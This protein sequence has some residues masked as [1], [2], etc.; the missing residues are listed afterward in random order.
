MIN[1][2]FEPK[3]C[4]SEV[5]T[6]T[7]IYKDMQRVVRDLAKSWGKTDCFNHGASIPHPS[8]EAVV[9]IIAR[10]RRILFPGYFTSN[11]I[12][13]GN[14]EY[15]LGQETTELF[16]RLSE[17]INLAIQ[18]DCFR[19]DQPCSHCNQ[20]GHT[21]ALQCIRALPAIQS[22]LVKD[23]QAALEGDPAAKGY[24]E[25]IFSYPGLLAIT[26]FRVAHELHR[27]GVP[28]IPI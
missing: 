1:N 9:E 19:F 24:D 28:V 17:Q 5:S 16:E 11:T 15:F 7:G 4:L 20:R 21:L 10:L 8:H 12:N 3:E 27:L 25:V 18:H 26:V 2:P 23:I 6:I 14:L 22:T 13:P